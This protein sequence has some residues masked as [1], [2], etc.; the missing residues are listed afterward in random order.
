MKPF[1]VLIPEGI[2]IEEIVNVNPSLFEEDY[3]KYLFSTI[4]T[5]QGSMI[6]NKEIDSDIENK[7][8]QKKDSTEIYIKI[9][10]LFQGGNYNKHNMLCE[11]LIRNNIT[12]KR[13]RTTQ[14]EVSIFERKKYRRGE[15]SFLYRLGWFF[16]NLRLKVSYITD[17][18]MI[19][20]I[21]QNQSR[22]DSE[23]KR[24]KYKFLNKFFDE[25][26]LKIDLEGAIL[27]CEE[28][29]TV[30]KDYSKYI[31]EFTQIVNIHNGVFRL[32]FKKDSVGRVYTN[33][34]QLNK[35]YRKFLT[36]NDKT[37]VEVDLSNSV[38]FF[39]GLM[40]NKGTIDR[41][42]DI[43]NN[44]TNSLI[45]ENSIS[46]LHMFSKSIETLSS[47]EIDLVQQ[48]SKNGRFYNSFVTDFEKLF[49]FDKMKFFYK[50]E[51]DDEY[52]GTEKQKKR[53]S[54]KQILAM[55]FARPT[56]Y[57]DIQEVFKIQ[58]PE[59]LKAINEFKDRVGYKKL[60]YLLFQIEAFFILNV[61]ARNF[62]KQYWR[63]APV[64]TLHDCLITT[65]DYS[66]ELEYCLE[67][68]LYDILGCAPKTEIKE[69]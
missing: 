13:S 26:S 68:N 30:H 2:D 4:I 44:K 36:Y 15:N 60:S 11:Y 20:T 19:K 66:G 43:F 49:S 58:F 7:K 37:L 40:L 63:K 27:K 48:L 42:I 3:V 17:Y 1:A 67:K 47:K 32:I 56:Q 33:L 51:N 29:Y 34:T 6:E 64:F 5:K 53:I 14:R 54:K 39:L 69:W 38:I 24:G 8:N 25:Q 9:E 57:S 35:E 62:N 22:C 59:L 28:R 50:N 46:T 16:R 41:F 12:I 65:S 23:L 31:K 45:N 10:A 21:K 18:K 55:L 52:V 61:A